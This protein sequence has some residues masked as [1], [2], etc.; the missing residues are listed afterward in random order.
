MSPPCFAALL[1]A[2]AAAFAAIPFLAG[3]YA[4]ASRSTC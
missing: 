1:A 2:T 3:D 4:I